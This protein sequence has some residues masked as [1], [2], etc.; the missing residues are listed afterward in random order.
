[1]TTLMI[2]EKLAAAEK[3]TIAGPDDPPAIDGLV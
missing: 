1:M 3:R 2:T